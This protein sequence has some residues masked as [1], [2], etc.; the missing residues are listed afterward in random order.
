MSQG[1]KY[2]KR[3]QWRNI[4]RDRAVAPINEEENEN[5]SLSSG[6]SEDQIDELNSRFNSDAKANFVEEMNLYKFSNLIPQSPSK[7][8]RGEMEM[9]VI[10][11]SV[12]LNLRQ[13]IKREF[14]N[15]VNQSLGSETQLTEKDLSSENKLLLQSVMERFELYKGF[16]LSTKIEDN[17]RVQELMASAVSREIIDLHLKKRIL[18]DGKIWIPNPD[19]LDSLKVIFKVSFDAYCKLFVGWLMIQNIAS[20]TSLVNLRVNS[21]SE[22]NALEYAKKELFSVFWKTLLA[23]WAM[24]GFIGSVSA[25]ARNLIGSLFDLVMPFESV[26]IGNPPINQSGLLSKLQVAIPEEYK[27]NVEFMK[28]YH[29]S[30]QNS[31]NGFRKWYNSQSVSDAS[32]L[33]SAAIEDGSSG[34]YAT[35]LD[36]NKTPWVPRIVGVSAIAAISDGAIALTREIIG[37]AYNP[38]RIGIVTRPAIS[39]PSVNQALYKMIE[40]FTVPFLERVIVRSTVVAFLAG[41][42]RSIYT[43]GVGAI[44]AAFNTSV[45]S[46]KNPLVQGAFQS[47]RHVV[48]SI[49]WVI[50]TTQC[51]KLYNDIKSRLNQKE[52]KSSVKQGN[53]E[54]MSDQMEMGRLT[55]MAARNMADYINFT[56]VSAQNDSDTKKKWIENMHQYY[57]V[58]NGDKA[59]KISIHDIE[60]LLFHVLPL[61]QL[62]LFQFYKNMEKNLEE[63]GKLRLEIKALNEEMQIAEHPLERDRITKLIQEKSTKFLDSKN[64][65]ERLKSDIDKINLLI[66]GTADLHPSN[67]SLQDIIREVQIKSNDLGEELEDEILNNNAMNVSED[68]VSICTI[69]NIE[70]YENIGNHNIRNSVPL[71]VEDLYSQD[72]RS[73]QSFYAQFESGITNIR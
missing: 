73:L 53:D 62:E 50:G 38:D 23:G 4:S 49:G 63:M 28:A 21:I 20:K 2:N 27:N 6:L 60:N 39:F 30:M 7:L 32:G 31:H 42:G 48:Q 44:D 55:C 18:K 12:R 56:L 9:R 45:I 22:T 35:Y 54:V 8:E 51:M 5:L 47:L 36:N 70:G 52:L 33:F 46:S 13:L 59:V 40:P 58:A 72:S 34:I 19:K 3:S 69:E 61:R 71:T 15:I 29:Y 1:N 41:L 11:S 67:L 16:T 57:V 64:N 17:D 26:T 14:L 68:N 65:I 43:S 10:S 25:A 66:R 37:A 24:R